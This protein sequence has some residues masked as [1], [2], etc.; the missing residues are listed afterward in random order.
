M[1]RQVLGEQECDTD[2][3]SRK[4]KRVFTVCGDFADSYDLA[5]DFAE[6]YRG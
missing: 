6:A 5:F 2:S 4:K 3:I 1:L